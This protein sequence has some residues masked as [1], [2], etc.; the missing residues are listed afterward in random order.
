MS[1]NNTPEGILL[2]VMNDENLN[3]DLRL[4]C[5]LAYIKIK[6]FGYRFEKDKIS[7]ILQAVKT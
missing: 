1:A 6:G 2:T 3:F 7:R 4:N 5:L